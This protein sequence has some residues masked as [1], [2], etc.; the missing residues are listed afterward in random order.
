MLKDVLEFMG[1][2]NIVLGLA[3]VCGIL[4]FFMT[5]IVTI[6]TANIGKILKYNQVS[7]QYNKERTAFQ[8]TFEGHRS[9]I[10]DDDIKSDKLL[11]DILKN[12]EEYRIKFGELLTRSEKIRLYF[13]I[14]ELKKEA[15]NVNWNSISNYLAIFSGR[16]AKREEKKNG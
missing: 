12:T 16:L 11:K 5:V 13:F 15:V 7:A 4:G 8:K 14:R 3:S 10:I 2:N 1:T 6:R 9:S